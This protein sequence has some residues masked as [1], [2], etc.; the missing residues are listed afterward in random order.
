MNGSVRS[1][2]AAL[3]DLVMLPGS[4]ILG[5]AAQRGAASADELW[6]V[7]R[8][9]EIWQAETW[10]QDEEAEQAAAAK[11]AGFAD[12]AK[13]YLGASAVSPTDRN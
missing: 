4:L 1:R 11:A 3:H 10:G 2:L 5:L 12:A 8:L 13:F 7:S 9:D 6:T